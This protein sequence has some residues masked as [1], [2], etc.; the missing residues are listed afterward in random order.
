MHACVRLCVFAVCV[1]GMK[2]KIQCQDVKGNPWKPCQ[3]GDSPQD[4][5]HYQ[6][7]WLETSP[8]LGKTFNLQAKIHKTQHT[9]AEA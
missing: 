1:R 6:V 5:Q 4:T 3:C 8:R 7:H 2:R 9:A